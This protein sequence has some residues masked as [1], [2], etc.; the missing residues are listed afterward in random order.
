MR[1]D[2]EKESITSE[3]QKKKR[4]IKDESNTEATHICEYVEFFSSKLKA[5]IKEDQW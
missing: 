2:L 5:K 3:D 4:E 1:V